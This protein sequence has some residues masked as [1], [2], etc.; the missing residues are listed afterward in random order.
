MPLASMIAAAGMWATG[1]TTYAAGRL[2]FMVLAALVPVV[3]AAVS[4]SLLHRRDLAMVSGLLGVFTIYYAPFLPVP[5]NYGAYIVL[6]GV[7]FLA[8]GW[9]SEAACFAMGLVAGLL[10]LARSDGLLWLLLTMAVVL[11]RYLRPKVET[12]S[13]ASTPLELF[14]RN[15]RRRV[16]SSRQAI[17][18]AVGFVLAA[19]PWFWRTHVIYGSL[20]APGGSHLLWLT[21]Y[22][23]TFLYPAS[24]LTASRWL[25]Q[26]WAS[27]LW[28]RFVAL[29]WNLLNA[30]AAQ[31]GIFLA[32]LI[33]AGIWRHRQ[34]PRIQV[35]ALGWL[36]LLFAMTIVFP[37]AGV[38]G[39][40]FHSGAALQSLWW[41]LAPSGLE[42]GVAAARRRNLFSPQAFSVFRASLVGIA[43]LM[44]AV[45]I[46]I[47]VLPDWGKA[48]AQ[49]AEVESFVERSGIRPGDVVMVRNPPGYYLMTGRPAVVVPYGD[50]ASMLAVAGRYDAK[51]VILESEGASG[52]IKSVYDERSD[53]RLH[54]MGEINGTRV[55]QVQP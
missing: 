45:I 17:L 42:A 7:F 43:A 41:A 3:T 44:T 4:F 32:P 51:Y 54:Y 16:S 48:E 53:G 22:D 13:R 55:F 34:D 19:G 5:D 29:K 36:A 47:R 38:R 9:Q 35:G 39:G 18:A 40:F 11:L 6:G 49:Y 31:G 20:L 25:A 46:S 2:G 1:S 37:F 50:A 27:I 28:A 26:G 10:T 14:E 21:N 24:G 15:S 52:P 12:R 30:F 8:M 23:E 33:L